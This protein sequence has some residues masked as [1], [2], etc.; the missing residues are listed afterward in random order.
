MNGERNLLRSNKYS[1]PDYQQTLDILDSINE[2]CYQLNSDCTVVYVNKR[3]QTILGLH[4]YEIIG[5][6]FW[7]VFPE[8]RDST[9]YHL[10]Q[11]TLQNGEFVQHEFLS[12]V[13]NTWISVSA[14]S[15]ESGCII[16]MYII[17]KPNETL[18]TKQGGDSKEIE[19]SRGLLEGIAQS[20]VVS[21]NVFK[22]VRNEED[23]LIDLCWLFANAS[24]KR[25]A[26]QSTLIGKRYSEV[27]PD[28]ASSIMEQYKMVIE[29]G[30]PH[31]YEFRDKLYETQRWYRSVAVKLGDGLLVTVEDITPRKKAEQELIKSTSILQ[32]IYDSLPISI[33]ILIPQYSFDGTIY[34]FKIRMVNKHLEVESGRRDLVGKLYLNEYPGVTASGIFDMMLRVMNSGI[35][36]QAEYYYGF[37]GFNKWFS[38]MFIKTYD[39][40]LSTN[41]D[42]TTRK[43]AD[44]ELMKNYQILRQAE[45]VAGIGSW[46]FVIDK[47]EFTWSEGMYKLFELDSQAAVSPETYLDFAVEEDLDIAKSIV[48]H[49]REDHL[50]FE[51]TMCIK[52]PTQRKTIRVK[53]VPLTDAA[54]R[55]VRVIGVDHD[56]TA[57]NKSENAL[58]EQHERMSEAQAISQL[59]SYEYDLKSNTVHWSD[60]LYRM[61]GVPLGTSLT[62]ETTLSHYLPEDARKL[63]KLLADSIEQAQGFELEASFRK[64][65]E[66]DIRNVFI[67]N[68]VV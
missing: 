36:E 54:G 58:L 1:M 51:E 9:L 38:T 40:L 41:L 25:F 15:I 50:P 14:T 2:G 12:G 48:K 47:N 60:E 19:Q 6:D 43:V 31:D 42:I 23:E 22:A 67:V 7:T 10:V 45:Q 30:Q 68:K 24:S 53:G 20:H 26:R 5:R 61:M 21:L 28:L 27:Y 46:D 56:I 8:G 13:L 52:T 39:G 11:Q 16:L 55:V 65:G 37:E 57:L 59:G 17:H 63:S 62:L 29:T 33:C 66:R 35:A 3:A 32:S 18:S 49:F 64:T 34:D 44:E 4:D